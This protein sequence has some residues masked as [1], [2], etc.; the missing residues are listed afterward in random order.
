MRVRGPKSI[1][2]EN[3]FGELTAKKWLDSVEKQKRR[4]SLK[5]RDRQR[6]RRSQLLHWR[7]QD[8]VLRGPENRGAA[9]FETPKASSG[10]ENGEGVSPSPAD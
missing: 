9:E 1:I 10:E 6:D 5:E 4:S 3:S 2:K 8:F 7:S